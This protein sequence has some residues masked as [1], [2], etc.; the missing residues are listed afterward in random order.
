MAA[1]LTKTEK[2]NTL[3]LKIATPREKGVR[4]DDRPRA[5]LYT[6]NIK[7]DTL[8]YIDAAYNRMSRECANRLWV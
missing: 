2:Q 1:D 7:I 4:E 8:L 5:I 6:D 3:K